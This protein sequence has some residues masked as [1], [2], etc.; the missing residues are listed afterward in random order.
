MNKKGF[1]LIEVLATVIILATICLV[2]FPVIR[3]T[4]QNNTNNQLSSFKKNAELAADTYLRVHQ[5]EDYNISFGSGTS[6]VSSYTLG[7]KEYLEIP[8][9]TLIKEKLMDKPNFD[10]DY[11]YDSVICS[12]TCEYG[13]TDIKEGTEY[14]IQDE[15]YIAIRNSF[16]AQDYVVLMKKRGLSI[17]DINTYGVGYINKYTKDNSGVPLEYTYEDGYR[18]GGVAYYG[19]L[20]CGYIN[21]SWVET[22]CK[23]DYKDSDIRHIIDN[24]SAAK[25]TNN[26]LKDV[27]G[28]ETRLI[29]YNELKPY[30]VFLGPNT[31]YETDLYQQFAFWVM[32]T[33]SGVIYIS[34]HTVKFLDSIRKYDPSSDIDESYEAEIRPVI[35]YKKDKL[36]ISE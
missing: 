17:N 1:T 13:E 23:T 19:N 4:L 11:K 31:Y 32:P 15:E 7:E 22:D 34:N 33:E 21:D 3:T 30:K 24:W 35:N 27:D 26:E 6:G 8:V 9:T 10:Y 25:F 14:T 20:L 12:K 2:S 28:Y 36:E 5:E 29:T 18:S 16:K